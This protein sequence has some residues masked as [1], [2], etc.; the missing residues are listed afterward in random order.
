MK[1]DDPDLE[2]LEDQFVKGGE[3]DEDWRLGQHT[4]F[5]IAVA[6][7]Q[8]GKSVFSGGGD[9]LLLCYRLN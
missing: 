1:E 4:D 3:S 2:E 9:D 8:D 5:C 7:A 6:V